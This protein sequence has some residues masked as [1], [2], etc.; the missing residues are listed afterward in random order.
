MLGQD[1]VHS[2]V[3]ALRVARVER[4]ATATGMSYE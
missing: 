4:T 2:A 1:E 3:I